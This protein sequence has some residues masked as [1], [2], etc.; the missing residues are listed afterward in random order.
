M[1]VLWWVVSKM[2]DRMPPFRRKK[3][4]KSFPVKVCTLDAELEFSL[5]VSLTTTSKIFV[6][7]R[8]TRNGIFHEARLLR[9]IHLLPLAS[10]SSGYPSAQELP[11]WVQN[12]CKHTLSHQWTVTCKLHAL[13]ISQYFRINL[14]YHLKEINF[15]LKILPS[16][17]LSLFFFFF[18][19]A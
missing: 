10:I 9:R 19:Y 2:K 12:P 8:F 15:F 7:L 4:G 13:K 6:F 17:T 16:L 3:S 11:L 1:C 18:W 14:F 5:E